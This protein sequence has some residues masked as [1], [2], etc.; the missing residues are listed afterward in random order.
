MKAAFTGLALLVFLLMTSQ[1][2][3]ITG[4]INPVH[5]DDTSWNLTSSQGYDVL[6][7]DMTVEQAPVGSEGYYYALNAIF[8]SGKN[9]Y[10]GLQTNGYNGSNW[11]GKMAIFSIWD[12][13]SGVP[14]SGGQGAS[15]GNEG[16]G[17][18][19]R[20]PFDWKVNTTYRFTIYLDQDAVSGN[21][22]WGAL[23]TDIAAGQSTRVG[24]IYAPV[25]Y[26]KVTRPVTFHE[27]YA[28][29][30]TSCN[31]LGHSRVVFANV[32][33]NNGAAKASKAEHYSV[34]RIPD[35]A[36]LLWL[37]DLNSGYRSTAGA[38]RPVASPAPAAAQPSPMPPSP[39]STTPVVNPSEISP[40]EG[41]LVSDEL[42]NRSP[43]QLNEPAQSSPMN[44]I[45][46][47]LGSAVLLAGFMFIAPYLQRYYRRK[48]H[49]KRHFKY[50]FDIHGYRRKRQREKRWSKTGARR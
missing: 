32:M 50:D 23:V 33:A 38:S 27:R 22:L 37:E 40:A 19:V 26:G 11:V 10:G 20:L 36:H 28:G 39:G 48:L 1:V 43:A 29:G 45:T 47:G 41:P 7:V 8:T 5:L 49:L 18:S 15:F 12:V 42:D 34:A 30:V 24:R 25:S 9:V 13:G 31:D 3:A 44:K 6:S 21:R 35:C 46:L 4:L 17:Y 2:S 16:S 14:E